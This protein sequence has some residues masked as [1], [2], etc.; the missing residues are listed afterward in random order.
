M[1]WMLWLL[2][3][4]VVGVWVFLLAV[5]R[6]AAK[7]PPTPAPAGMSRETRESREQVWE[8]MFRVSEA[9]IEALAIAY[10]HAHRERGRGSSP[11]EG[12]TVGARAVSGAS[13]RTGRRLVPRLPGFVAV[14]HGEAGYVWPSARIQKQQAD[15]EGG[16]SRRSE[17]S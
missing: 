3:I 9:E 8:K 12:R 10:G 6:A 5:L 2:A 7:K 14:A 15:T 4:P 1:L 13:E 16:V 17:E 11:Q